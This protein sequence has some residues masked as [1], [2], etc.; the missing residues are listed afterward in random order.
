[1]SRILFPKYSVLM[2]VYCKEKPEFLE[3]AIQSIYDQTVKTDDFVLI[4]DG[5]LTEELDKVID[6]F[7]TKFGD[8]MNIVRFEENHGLG[9]ALNVG[10]TLC[11]NELIAR[12]DSDDISKKDRC[13]KELKKFM[14][15]DTL[16][17]VGSNILEFTET[18]EK[19]DILR[20]VP[21]LNED[22]IKFSKKR[23]PFN[24][25]S[26]MYKKSAVIESGNY[27]SVRHMQDYYL[28]VDMLTNNKKGYN[29]QEPLVFMRASNDLYKRRSGREYIKIQ[30]NLFRIMRERHYI[31]ILEYYSSI[32]IRTLSAFAPNF[33]RKR[34]FKKFLRKKVS[35]NYAY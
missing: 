15:D 16:S 21:E 31:T 9:H 27:R 20:K 29:I 12:M 34:V 11:K 13:E 25:P 2:S 14:E 3:Q 35:D 19:A 10:V 4:C 6:K 1:M 22:I 33:L 28:W 32:T 8:V 5:K 17:I 18:P 26:V 24:H 23:C 30:N 7:K